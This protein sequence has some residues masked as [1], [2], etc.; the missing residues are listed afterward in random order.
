MPP[1]LHSW[2]AKKTT[3]PPK[4]YNYDL[5]CAFPPSQIEDYERLN[6]T[7]ETSV[8]LALKDGADS[9]CTLLKY[10]IMFLKGF[11]VD[12]QRQHSA[13]EATGVASPTD[14]KSGSSS[15]SDGL[16]ELDPSELEHLNWDIFENPID[17]IPWAKCRLSPDATQIHP[18]DLMAAKV[19]AYILP[20]VLNPA[21]R[22]EIVR[23]IAE[24]E[25]FKLRV[26]ATLEGGSD[27][28]S[29]LTR[30]LASAENEFLK[31]IDQLVGD[32]KADAVANSLD[33]AES[34]HARLRA[35]GAAPA[36]AAADKG[37]DGGKFI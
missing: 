18:R 4:N 7:F 6:R 12:W 15:E 22:A 35:R 26:K 24:M 31:S 37:A 13:L 25:S 17:G 16:M 33:A 11:D 29:F 14:D 8:K 3:Q 36:A 23:F 19:G 30:Q 1:L 32:D 34:T 10:D 9:M 2:T 21:I 5:S 27:P 20:K 28:M